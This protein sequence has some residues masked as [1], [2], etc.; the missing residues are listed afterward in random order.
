MLPRSGKH[1]LS[2][3]R[4][5]AGKLDSYFGTESPP[6]HKLLVVRYAMQLALDVDALAGWGKPDFAR[7]F[8]LGNTEQKPNDGDNNQPSIR[9][10]RM[11]HQGI[12]C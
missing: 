2:P 3:Q 12:N 7:A 8:S 10:G 6:K 11:L 1:H 9:R 5:G 4:P